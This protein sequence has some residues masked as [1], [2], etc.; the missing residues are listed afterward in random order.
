M[1][2]KKHSKGNETHS[3]KATSAKQQILLIARWFMW[4]SFRLS[5]KL[6]KH[7]TI[8]RNIEHSLT[9][10]SLGIHLKLVTLVSRLRRF[11]DVVIISFGNSVIYITVWYFENERRYERAVSRWRTRGDVRELSASRHHIR[12]RLEVVVRLAVCK[13]IQRADGLRIPTSGFLVPTLGC[14]FLA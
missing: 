14:G 11:C 12:S 2:S 8:V 13:G 7:I 9:D 6:I 5:Y 10:K 1:R 4:I 3:N